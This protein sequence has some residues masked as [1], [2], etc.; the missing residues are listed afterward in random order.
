[1]G[2]TTIHER[3][4]ELWTVRSAREWTDEER[5]DVEHCLAVNAAHFRRLAHLYNLSLLASMTGDTEWQHDICA[6]IE[7]MGGK[8]PASRML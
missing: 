3:L 4:A 5:I 1:M 2:I 6:E 7:K 8:P